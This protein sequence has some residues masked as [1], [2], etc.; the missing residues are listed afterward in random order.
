MCQQQE[1]LQFADHCRQLLNEHSIPAHHDTL[2]RMADA[3]LRLA[4]EEKRIA[5]LVREADALFASA[6]NAD[7]RLARARSIRARLQ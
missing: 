4:A 2:L 1:F 6:G 7:A 3:W 5:D